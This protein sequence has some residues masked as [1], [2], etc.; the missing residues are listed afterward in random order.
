[1]R[2][3]IISVTKVRAEKLRNAGPAVEVRLRV[4]GGDDVTTYMTNPYRKAD[5]MDGGNDMDGGGF[6]IGR[7]AKSFK[8]VMKKAAPV[9][10]K[11]SDAAM[12]A[13]TVTGQPELLAAGAAGK[14]TATL[15]DES[16]KTS[17]PTRYSLTVVP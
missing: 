9:I 15:V 4:I 2:P 6:N 16:K 11:L 5:D 7:A 13:G 3:T 1:M 17:K 10:D 14:A 12:I 8:T